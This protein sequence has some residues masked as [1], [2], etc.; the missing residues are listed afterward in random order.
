[1]N[2]DKCLVRR[3]AAAAAFVSASP[4]SAAAGSPISDV[5][6]LDSGATHHLW[7]TYRAFIG[8]KRVY[9]QHATLA[10]NSKIRIADRGTIVI[11]MRGKKLI[12]RD[13]YHVP[14]LRLPLFSLRVHRRMPGCGYHSDNDGV[15]CF[16]LAFQLE[17][18]DEVGTYVKCRPITSSTK[19]FDYIQP[20]ASASSA[21]A[22]SFP[23]RRSPRLNTSPVTPRQRS[24][25]LVARPLAVP[26]VAPPATS[27]APRLVPTAPPVPPV[28]APAETSV[29]V[30]PRTPPLTT[31]ALLEEDDITY[32][33]EDDEELG[34]NAPEV[35]H[36]PRRSSRPR[37]QTARINLAALD[38]LAQ[39]CPRIPHSP[40]PSVGAEAG[41]AAHAHQRRDTASVFNRPR[42]STSGRAPMRHPQCVRIP[43]RPHL[44]Q[45]I[46]HFWKPTVS[47][48]R[49]VW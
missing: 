3:G 14:D 34:E 42:R 46:P 24:P 41:A 26:P 19:V 12:I 20:R 10:N 22:A 44:R 33:Y 40:N 39:R 16:F 27:A 28:T 7:P 11:V 17:V 31:P 45:E 25:R 2:A 21:A 18:D 8:Y 5:A 15:Y 6:I 4:V 47:E 49:E 35:D 36:D 29:N 43:A 32:E 30:P 37:F 23:R 38:M 13:V 9:G 48:L 1:M